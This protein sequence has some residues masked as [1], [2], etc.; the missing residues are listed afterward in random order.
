MDSGEKGGRGLRP[1]GAGVSWMDMGLVAATG[2]GGGLL[3]WRGEVAG[4]WKTLRAWERSVA[5]IQ[6]VTLEVPEQ[7]K[8]CVV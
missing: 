6:L 4:V 5:L 1:A 8:A 2:V 3:R 7:A